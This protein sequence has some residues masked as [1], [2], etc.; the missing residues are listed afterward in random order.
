MLGSDSSYMDIHEKLEQALDLLFH[1]V[2]NAADDGVFGLQHVHSP[3]R[4]T[5][6]PSRSKKRK[7]EGPQSV[8]EEDF[9]KR[10]SM[11][12]EAARSGGGKPRG[13]QYRLEQISPLQG[14]CCTTSCPADH[15]HAPPSVHE[16]FNFAWITCE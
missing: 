8:F 14:A 6:K 5:G 1:D 3:E 7:R 12:V 10:L 2:E 9:H 4:P 16:F 15:A 13:D 11:L